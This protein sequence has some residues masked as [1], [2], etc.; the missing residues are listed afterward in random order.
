MWRN[1]V[2]ITLGQTINSTKGETPF[3][4]IIF[5]TTFAIFSRHHSILADNDVQ[6][7]KNILRGIIDMDKHA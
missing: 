1:N 7:Q 5:T 4:K 6:P 3:K 2:Q